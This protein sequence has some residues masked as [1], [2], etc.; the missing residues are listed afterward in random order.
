MS[1]DDSYVLSIDCSRG[2]I[3]AELAAFLMMAVGKAFPHSTIADSGAA[4]GIRV[5]RADLDAY[6]S[7]NA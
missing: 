2:G 4:V 7:A 5:T 1:D 6:S 3:P